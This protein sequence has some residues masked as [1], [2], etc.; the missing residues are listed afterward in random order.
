MRIRI[1]LYEKPPSTQHLYGNMVRGKRVIRFMTKEG[2]DFK[3]RLATAAIKAVQTAGLEFPFQDK[4]SM[5]LQLKFKD[6]RRR[7]IDNY[8]KVIL[9]A[10]QGIVY[11]DDKQI[12]DLEI[13]K[14]SDCIEDRIIV[15]VEPMR[16]IKDE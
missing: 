8:N 3:G 1:E 15:E 4:V 9:D 10:L 6:K 5:N 12:C 7:D 16:E 2:K 13:T 14:D 11:E